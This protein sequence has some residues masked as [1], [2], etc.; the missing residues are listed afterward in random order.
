MIGVGNTVTCQTVCGDKLTAGSEQCDD[1][2]TN[3]GDGCSN[4]CQ[5]EYDWSCAGQPSVCTNL[6]GNFKWDSGE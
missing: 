5:V 3:N 2:N 4:T 1:G 6:C